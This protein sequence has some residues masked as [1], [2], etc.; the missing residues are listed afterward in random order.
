MVVPLVVLALLAICAGWFNVTG[1]FSMLMGGEAEE[2]N[3][4]AFF[5]GVFSHPLP[6]ISLIVALLGIFLA[7][8]MYIAK[9]ISAEKIG[10]AFKP[11]LHAALPQILHGRALREHLRQNDFI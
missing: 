4:A 6:L 8:A 1:G 7:Y 3:L 5:L 2:T 11:I 10:K 9:W